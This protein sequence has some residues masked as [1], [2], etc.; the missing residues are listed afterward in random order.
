MLRHSH[1]LRRIGRAAFKAMRNR[2]PGDPIPRNSMGP[3]GMAEQKKRPAA[4]SR[5]AMLLPFLALVLLGC[6]SLSAQTW[7]LVW[8]S[9]FNGPAGSAPNPAKWTYETGNNNGWGNQ[10][11]EYYCPPTDNT[12]PCSTTQPNIYEDGNGHLVIAAIHTS[13][14]AASGPRAV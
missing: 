6:G 1:P 4:S 7:T 5:R 3:M 9:E 10:E 2:K 11:Q 8:S 12:D 14:R 13:H